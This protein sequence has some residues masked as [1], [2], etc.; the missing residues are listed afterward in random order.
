MCFPRF[1]LF[2]GILV[3]GA[4]GNLLV[5]PSLLLAAEK[6][7]A[8]ELVKA[9]G[10]E[11][12]DWP[13]WRGL[14]RDAVSLET[15]L[16]D[17]WPTRGPKLLWTFGDAGAG[18]SAP[19]VQG[20]RLY[21]M[22]GKEGKTWIYCLNLKNGKLVWA[23]PL[24]EVF[25]NDWG[26]GPRG[27]VTVDGNYLYGITGSG[28]FFC[29]DAKGGKGKWSRHLVNDFGGGVPNWGY[30]ESPLVIGDR[31]LA[32]PGG[33]NCI[34][35][36][37]K[38][39][40][41]TIWTSTGLDDAAQYSSLVPFAIDGVEM[42]TTMTARGL[43]GVA[44]NSGEFLWRYEKTANGTAVIPTP[45]V[46]V[47]YVYST[48]GY[49]TGCGLVKLTVK[50]S[51]VEAEEVYFDRSMKNQHGGVLRLGD[52]IYGYSDGGGWLCQDFLTGDVVWRERKVAKGS[53]ACADGKL[54]CYT[55]DEG[56]MVMAAAT[57]D[58]WQELGRFTIPKKSEMPRKSGQIWTHPVIAD[59]KLFLRD[60]ELLFC[61]DIEK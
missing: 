56:T 30:T 46:R 5:A 54:Y 40:G 49:G 4:G 36:L 3:A 23:T 9:R 39:N 58:G 31:V 37:D 21:A 26:D 61:F 6:G 38:R 29:V 7:A 57:P 41:E 35:A 51:A 25:I 18:Y 15:G 2:F 11:P 16:A 50:G 17:K 42:V 19:S 44:A 28:L 10:S 60:H 33:K 45:V 32:T 52:H 24:D 22:G 20:N 34:V 1:L 43:V 8:I 48:S 12:R 14:H 53:I 47:P 55:E 13:Q 27:S 59:G